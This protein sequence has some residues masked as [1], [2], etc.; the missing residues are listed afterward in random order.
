[1]PFSS[2]GG[3]VISGATFKI[4]FATVTLSI[5]VKLDTSLAATPLIIS[6]SSVMCLIRPSVSLLRMPFSLTMPSAIVSS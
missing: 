5:V 2:S 3:S 4:A 1:M 6:I